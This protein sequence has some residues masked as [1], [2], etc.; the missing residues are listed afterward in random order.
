MSTHVARADAFPGR[1]RD[2]VDLDH[3]ATTPPGPCGDLDALDEALT[4]CKINRSGLLSLPKK[5]P[6]ANLLG[7]VVAEDDPE[8]PDLDAVGARPD[9]DRF[10]APFALSNLDLVQ[11]E[12][13][14]ADARRAQ[15]LPVVRPLAKGCAGDA[16]HRNE[17]GRQKCRH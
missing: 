17:K 14:P 4:A 13:V 15:Q 2:G 6:Q 11:I 5:V 9:T 3:C 10:E 8:I 16:H 1:R 12:T 7:L